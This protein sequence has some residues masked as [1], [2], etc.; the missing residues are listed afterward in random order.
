VD[1]RGKHLA[2]YLADH[3]MVQQRLALLF[4]GDAL[5][6]AIRDPVFDE[7]LIHTKD[8][9]LRAY[10]PPMGGRV[11]ILSDL[12]CLARDAGRARRFW[13]R[14]GRRL[15][16]AKCEAVALL[17]CSPRQCGSE[18]RALYRLISWE[19]PAPPMLNPA[20]NEAAC[21]LL[22]RQLAPTKRFSPGLL[23]AVRLALGA[24]SPPA[25]VES[26]LW[27]HQATQDLNPTVSA[28]K[29][30]EV[31]RRRTEFGTQDFEL[32]KRVLEIIRGWH[33][34]LPGE[35]FC[36]VLW[37][38]PERARAAARPEDLHKAERFFAHIANRSREDSAKQL[39]TSGR[40]WVDRNLSQLS[41][42]ARNNPA[43]A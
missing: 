10:Q 34:D 26:L 24:D 33:Y 41:E 20:Q 1:D 21:E 28:L 16:A 23:R 29:P 12:G 15:R 25:G 4:S 35:V 38:L 43:L 31:A 14:F 17:P 40:A 36:S 2:P 8:G 13:G 42:S 3:M 9:G 22:L 5:E 37:N 27:Q 19:H 39:R 11:L 30:E 7:P 32:Q 6:T 18:L